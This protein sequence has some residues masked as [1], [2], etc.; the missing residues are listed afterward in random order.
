MAARKSNWQAVKVPMGQL[1][2]GIGESVRYWSDVVVADADGLFLPFF[3]HRREHGVISPEARQVV[4]SMQHLWVR[5]RQP[6]LASARLAVVRFPSDGASR[7][8]QVKFHREQ[9]LLPYDVID[10]RIRNV[11]ETWAR[12]SSER[13]RSDMEKRTGTGGLFD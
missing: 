9:D 2:I 1:P 10:A 8:I 13:T 7:S 5:E 6:D 12:V 4:H 11:Y 3:D